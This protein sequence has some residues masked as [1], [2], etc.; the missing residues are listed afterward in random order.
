MLELQLRYSRR[1]V[2]Y[3]HCS[4]A[5]FTRVKDIFHSTSTSVVA[6]NWQLLFSSPPWEQLRSKPS[7]ALCSSKKWIW[8]KYKKSH[9][10]QNGGIYFTVQ[11]NSNDAWT[12]FWWRQDSFTPMDSCF[13]VR[14]GHCRHFIAA[15]IDV[16]LNL[17]CTCRF[18]MKCGQKWTLEMLITKYML[19]CIYL[20]TS[21]VL[22]HIGEAV[23]D[24]SMAL[25]Q[26][27]MCRLLLLGI[28]GAFFWS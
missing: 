17:I 3:V 14:W 24:V 4:A 7:A 8:K 1:S 21:C 6:T 19:Y 12:V 11:Y 25:F 13:R 18:D 5:A 23:L 20:I 26:N 16:A 28:K 15:F 2:V 22:H 10:A 9:F 27:L